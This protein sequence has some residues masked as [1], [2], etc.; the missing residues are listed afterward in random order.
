VNWF[1][2]WNKQNGSHGKQIKRSKSTCPVI[3]LKGIWVY[4]KWA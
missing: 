4:L 3:I 1:K 2:G